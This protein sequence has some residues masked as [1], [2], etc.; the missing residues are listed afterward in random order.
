[1]KMVLFHINNALNLNRT[2]GNAMGSTA[3][4]TGSF[5]LPSLSKSKV[6]AQPLAKADREALDNC[7]RAFDME[8]GL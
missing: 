4:M 1:M 8:R 3:T 2:S 7:W 6:M 5:T